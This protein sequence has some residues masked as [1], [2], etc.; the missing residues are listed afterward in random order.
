MT[1]EEQ[2]QQARIIRR[3]YAQNLRDH[4]SA[5]QALVA[6]GDHPG[7][8]AEL[9]AIARGEPQKRDHILREYAEKR[10]DHESAFQALVALGTPPNEVEIWLATARGER[11]KFDSSSV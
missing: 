8:A 4:N 11:P 2:I 5:L 1:R 9:L 6:L 7:D 10:L 3:E